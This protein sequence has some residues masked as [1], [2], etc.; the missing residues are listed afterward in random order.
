[1]S[2]SKLEKSAWLPYFNGMSKVLDGK[3]AEIEIDALAIGSQIEAEWL[4]L[5]GITYDPR[6]DIVDII[7]EGLDHRIYKPK[8]LYIDHEAAELS[9]VE[10]IDGDDV[11]H[12]VRLRDPLMLPAPPQQH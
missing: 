5:L 12:I 9:S 7:L 2:I 1:M 11:R 8:E 3:R 10:V 4:P 6:S